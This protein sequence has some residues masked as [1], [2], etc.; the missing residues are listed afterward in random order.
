MLV[1]EVLMIARHS[2]VR[3]VY[4]GTVGA[5]LAFFIAAGVGLQAQSGGQAIRACVTEEGILRVIGPNESCKGKRELLTWG[6]DGPTGPT[7]PAG[8]AGPTGPAGPQGPAGR[9]ATTPAPPPTMFEAQLLI[10][11][12]SAQPS[13]V[14]ALSFGASN[15]VSIGSGSGGAGAGKVS[16]S[17]MNIMKMLDGLSVPLLMAAST[18]AAL[19]EVIITVFDVSGPGRTQIAKYTLET[20]FVESSQF[21]SS[22]SSIGESVSFAFQKITSDITINGATFHSCWDVAA[23][24]SC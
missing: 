16:W 12:K 15:P 8:P 18:G 5:G 11:S 1:Q 24:G 13:P 7:G 2:G 6:V 22:S 4:A 19:P 14:L 23:N 21:S 3:I 17:S 10:Q 20:A 9:D